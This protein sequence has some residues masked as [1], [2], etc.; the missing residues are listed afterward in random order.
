MPSFRPTSLSV[1][2]KRRED[3][4]ACRQQMIGPLPDS[5]M[6]F[7]LVYVPFG[8]LRCSQGL[9]VQKRFKMADGD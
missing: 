4:G 3:K 6:H 7:A 2:L 8:A 5:Q 9:G 1:G